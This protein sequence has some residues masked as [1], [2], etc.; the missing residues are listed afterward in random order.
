MSGN[1]VSGIQ[2]RGKGE[3]LYVPYNTDANIVKYLWNE[4]METFV[5]FKNSK[6]SNDFNQGNSTN[7]SPN[8][9]VVSL[10]TIG[11]LQVVHICNPRSPS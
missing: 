1:V 11:R 5:F 8:S 6:G 2:G 10:D 4:N 3:L 7:S 9:V